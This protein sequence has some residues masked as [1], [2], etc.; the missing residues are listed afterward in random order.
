MAG[1]GS[2]G[3]NTNPAANAANL[4]TAFGTGM[5]NA[6]ATQYAR[7]QQGIQNQIE[8]DKVQYGYAGKYNSAIVN[9]QSRVQAAYERAVAMKDVAG[10]QAA[11][12]EGQAIGYDPSQ[13]EG[14]IIGGANNLPAP[15]P[16]TN[17]PLF[18]PGGSGPPQSPGDSS[19]GL[20]PAPQPGGSNIATPVVPAGAP[21]VIV[22]PSDPSSPVGVVP[23]GGPAPP[24]VA[25]TGPGPASL[26]TDP[27]APPPV[28]PAPA[29]NVAPTGNMPPP[30]FSGKSGGTTGAKY[31]SDAARQTAA[32]AAITRAKNST[33]ATQFKD[34]QAIAGM[35]PATQK[36]YIPKYNQ[37]YGDNL[38]PN[39]TLSPDLLT[40]AKVTNLGADT[41]LTNIKANDQTA[42]DQAHISELHAAAQYMGTKGWQINQVTP[43]E[44]LKNNALASF[45]GTNA[46]HVSEEM[47][48]DPILSTAV[49]VLDG[50]LKVKNGIIPPTGDNLTQL[51]AIITKAQTTISD[52]T[53]RDQ[54]NGT[55]GGTSAPAG[56]Y[57]S[58]SVD[59]SKLSPASITALHSGGQVKVGKYL[60]GM[61]NNRPMVL[62]LAPDGGQ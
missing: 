49:S 15:V 10:I 45:L 12:R 9:A 53:K 61:V 44:I 62:G 56:G 1:Y 14:S 18:T 5:M 16:G 2:D 27:N 34:L 29:Q 32:D 24:I 21:P 22:S 60:I 7:Q 4:L 57:S 37:M 38:D 6:K 20:G 35:D 55:P 23:A 54:Q 11:Q 48:N 50:A 51:N 8:Q 19:V 43:S 52:R 30:D 47:P 59:S 17:L 46:N 36:V 25:P 31:T 39:T 28:V 13:L 58:I 33:N 3:Y 26:P 42:L 41:R 40:Q